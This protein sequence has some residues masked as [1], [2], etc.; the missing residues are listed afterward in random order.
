MKRPPCIAPFVL[1]A[2]LAAVAPAQDL[3]APEL[4][5]RMKASAEAVQDASFLLTGSLND[6]DGT[7]IPLEVEIELIPGERALRA[8]FLQPDALADNFIVLEGDVVYNYNY[9]TNQVTL[10][11]A[12]D[13]DAFG[14][15]IGEEQVREGEG[16]D[17]SL[18]LDALFANWEATVTGYG[19][20]PAGPAYE[21]RFEALEPD[22][23]VAHVD[24]RVLDESF[25]PYSL[26]FVTAEGETLAS[27]TL[28]NLE[29]DLGLDPAD[30]TYIPDDAERIDERN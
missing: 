11:D 14:G 17:L 23:A 5:D 27:L 18:D 9:L 28:E 16:L 26:T 3:E 21:L 30:V 7:R 22:A 15:L 24:A 4:L 25:L 10:F 2:V 1:L 8:T 19:D 29:T 20:T 13:P 6:P 12:D